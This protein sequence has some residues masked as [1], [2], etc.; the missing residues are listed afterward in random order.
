MWNGAH[1]IIN[2][3]AR[4]MQKQINWLA[5]IFCDARSV[6]VRGGGERRGG[7]MGGPHGPVVKAAYLIY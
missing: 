3:I 5:C 4:I 7:G 2:G 1:S 6:R